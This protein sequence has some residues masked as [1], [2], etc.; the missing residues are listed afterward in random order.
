MTWPSGTIRADGLPDF[1]GETAVCEQLVESGK[2]TEQ[3]QKIAFLL[4]VQ[5]LP[6]GKLVHPEHFVNSV[7][8]E[9]CSLEMITHIDPSKFCAGEMS[10][11]GIG[12]T[13]IARKMSN[14]AF[15][16]LGYANLR[17]LSLRLFGTA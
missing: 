1:A 11:A 15:H 2:L 10:L 6:V 5:P 13:G 12:S 17:N 16:V 4:F 7:C 14:E 9:V 3:P 8:R